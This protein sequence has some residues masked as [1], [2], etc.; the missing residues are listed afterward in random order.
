MTEIHRG[1]ALKGEWTVN[2][3]RE[4]LL[5]AM[6]LGALAR[7]RTIL[8]D[9]ANTPVS[10][11]YATWLRSNGVDIF[12]KENTWELEGKG[13]TGT[14]SPSQNLPTDSFAQHLAL[15][16]LSRDHETCFD[17]GSEAE[18]GSI[19]A[20][21]KNF[22]G[23]FHEGRFTF[24]EPSLTYKL[25]PSGEVPHLIRIRI[26]LQALL[27][28]RSVSFEERITVRDQLSGLLT[29][30]G[31]P[32]TVE[33]TGPDELD[34]LARRMARMQG[35][36][37]ERKTITKLSPCKILAGKEIFIPGD[38]TEASA[39]ALLA[40]SLPDSDIT[41]RNIVLN[42]GRSGVFTALKRMGANIEVVQKRERYGD[43]FGSL[44]VQS[45][46]R[47]VGRKFTGEVLQT[48]IEEIPMLAIAASLA[49]GETILRLPEHLAEAEH[50][51]LDALANNLKLAGI[52]IGIYEE[53]LVVRG[54]EE[55]DANPFDSH[56][57]A[58]LGLALAVLARIAHGHSLVEGLDYTQ[59]T[60]PGLLAKLG[61]V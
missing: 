46:K 42:P 14:F 23:P 16:L 51:L 61:V 34:E 7:G 47:P 9:C 3:D 53:G 6:T 19:G 50:P 52:E 4:M 21:L 11:A 30:F 36:K 18:S 49:E 1:Q 17:L 32:L 55:I 31:A 22:V 38:P 8:E 25:S 44:R 29:F 13:L 58:I 15:C 59:T 35:Q 43:Q 37:L 33:T 27:H 57:S 48:C 40:S 60:F 20:K 28:E 45:C 24:G 26:L 39:V 54:R 10:E 2:P 12:R 56:G 41:L 5:Y